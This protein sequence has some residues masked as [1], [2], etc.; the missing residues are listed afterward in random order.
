LGNNPSVVL[1]LFA[2]V[3]LSVG[4]AFYFVNK[5]IMLVHEKASLRTVILSFLFALPISYFVLVPLVGFGAWFLVQMISPNAIQT[6]PEAGLFVSLMA[7]W[8]PLW[9]APMLATFISWRYL[10]PKWK[11]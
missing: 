10:A 5:K 9:P 8:F 2:C 3:L 7:V 4:L 1:S 6:N 11:L